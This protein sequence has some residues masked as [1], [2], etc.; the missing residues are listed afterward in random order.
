MEGWPSTCETPGGAPRATS[1]QV[2]IDST[3]LSWLVATPR[4]CSAASISTV[5]TAIS[6]AEIEG[7]V[8]ASQ[9]VHKCID[10]T[11]IK[12]SVG[13]REDKG[14]HWAASAVIGNLVAQCMQL[15][16]C[17]IRKEK[18]RATHLDKRN[19]SCRILCNQLA[20]LRLERIDPPI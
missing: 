13:V 5:A 9:G 18:R 7:E 16:N 15:G 11:E 8:N 19:G 12:L 4:S 6:A 14:L 1:R 2:G 10:R 20:E 17:R 3:A